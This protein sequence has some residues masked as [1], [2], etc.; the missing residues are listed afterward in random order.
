M[1][2]NNSDREVVINIP[3]QKNSKLKHVKTFPEHLYAMKQSIVEN[4][5]FILKS[6]MLCLESV[7]SGLLFNT[8]ASLAGFKGE[9][10]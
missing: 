6:S 9:A 2:S 10:C 3:I 4:W 5:V 8:L 1:K 7:C